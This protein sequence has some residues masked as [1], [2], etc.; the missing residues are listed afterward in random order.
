MNRVLILASVGLVRWTT[1]MTW[2]NILIPDIAHVL[3]LI[4]VCIVHSIDML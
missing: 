3:S 1:D 4:D 2:T